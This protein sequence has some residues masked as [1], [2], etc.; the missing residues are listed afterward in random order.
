MCGPHTRVRAND[1][2]FTYLRL[3][4]IS[5]VSGKELTSSMIIDLGIE[6]LYRDMID[7]IERKGGRL[8]IYEMAKELM[9]NN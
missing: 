1:A 2:S 9:Q 7:E 5:P 3:G 4:T 6:R 8:C